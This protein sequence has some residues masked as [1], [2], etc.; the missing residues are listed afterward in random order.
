VEAGLS[1]FYIGSGKGN[2]A[3]MN[4][5]NPKGIE[6]YCELVGDKYT[7]ASDG[8]IAHKPDILVEGLVELEP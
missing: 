4:F 2:L 8:S 7:F 5:D 1:C 3:D 6:T